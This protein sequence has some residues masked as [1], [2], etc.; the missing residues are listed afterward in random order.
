MNE[1]RKKSNFLTFGIEIQ[2]SDQNIGIDT[3]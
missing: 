2:I 3:N 1:N